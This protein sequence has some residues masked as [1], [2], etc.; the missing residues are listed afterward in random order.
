M[1][2]KEFILDK[3]KP[4][5][6]PRHQ[7]K[8]FAR[9]IVRLEGKTLANVNIIVAFLYCDSTPQVKKNPRTD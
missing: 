1:F 2:S 5:K 4:G 6:K 7:M 3:N 9:I 8:T